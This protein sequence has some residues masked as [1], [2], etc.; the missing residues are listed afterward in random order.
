[1]KR[2][3]DIERHG[4]LEPGGAIIKARWPE[5]AAM[6]ASRFERQVQTVYLDPPFFSGKA[7]SLRLPI[8]DVGNNTAHTLLA[9]DDRWADEHLYLDMIRSSLE[10]ARSIMLPSGAI[11]LHIDSRMSG[12][13]RA[14]MDDIFGEKNFV[15]EII[16]VYKTGGR[17]KLRFS[18]K[19]DTI[20][21]YKKSAALYFDIEQAAVARKQ[22]RNHMRRAQDDSG[23]WYSSINSGGKEYR[24]YDDD[25]AYPSDV[26]D[27]VPPM[28]QRDPRRCG[29]ETQKP[30]AL[31]ERIIK[32]SS[33][34]G[35]IAADLFAGSG[36]AAVA[37]ASLGRR[38]I[39][40]DASAL[41]I[42]TARKR[43]AGTSFT[44]TAP[45]DAGDP[46]VEV[47]LSRDG[48]RLCASLERYECESDICNIPS[49]ALTQLDQWSF[50]ALIGREFHALAS[51]SR[52]KLSPA[53]ARQL[54][55]DLGD[56][57]GAIP[58]V[59]TVDILGRRMLH[60]SPGS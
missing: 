50:G 5:D 4:G 15:N 20:L 2:S 19:H 47:S 17:T 13:L 58:A 8:G 54:E 53:L 1:M 48:S 55:A 34:E 52:T 60:I 31:L 38:F 30:D 29:F 42:Q 24:Y 40:A 11:F 23:R 22:K 7:Y 18:P 39:A 44:L 49:D 25:A 57:A 21:F 56:I 3:F 28:Q 37:A 36:T 35:D 27:D 10:C 51:D 41:S 14:M 6:F 16:W 9:Y 33:R 32:C 26:W 12:K 45:D 59:V 46:I 43:L